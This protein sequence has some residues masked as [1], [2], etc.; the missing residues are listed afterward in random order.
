MRKLLIIGAGS[1]GQS[2]AK[3]ILAYRG[4]RY[5]IVGFLDDQLAGREF[6]GK[7]VLGRVD[8]ARDIIFRY[9]IDEVLIAIPSANRETM[10]RIFQ[11]LAYTPVHI[12]VVP[13]L[14]EIIEGTV[15]LSQVRQIEP[16]DLL[17]RE[18]VTLDPERL[19]SLYE[20][21][22]V[23]VTGGGGSIGSELVRQLLSLPIRKVVAVGRGENSLYE[24]LQSVRDTR[25]SY[26]IADI[27]DRDLM[28]Y[29]FTSFRPHVVFHAAAHKHVPFMEEF[30]HEA[31]MNNILGT[32]HVYQ[33]AKEAGTERFVMISTDKAVHPTSVMGATKRLA[34]LLVLSAGQEDPIRVSA[35]RFGNVLGSRGSVLPLFIRQIQQGGP[36]TITHPEMKRYF[37]SIREASRLVIQ[38][39]TLLEG[40]IHILDMGE[41][42]S[43]LEMARTLI[44]LYGHRPEDI[45]IVFTGLRPGE[46][47]TEELVE[48][49][50]QLYPSEF[51]KL[52][53]TKEKIFWSSEKREIFLKE[54]REAIKTYE[55]AKVKQFLRQWLPDY[56]GG[57]L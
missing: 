55:P 20:D 48:N 19:R 53:Y 22:V 5:E 37:M 34:E 13:G 10:R 14:L 30:P 32:W 42:I 9:E 1:A 3:E 12:K 15:S 44:A 21:K 29:E 16:V 43:I 50:E 40:D 7:P 47:L 24:L 36:V 11:A 25:L 28:K 17:G 46:K 31:V 39:A 41:P 33:A 2:L 49:P 38:S 51:K 26:R 52:F 56:H 23:L 18:E 57:S 35:V 6:L 45:E 54:A 8:E 4:D 27:R